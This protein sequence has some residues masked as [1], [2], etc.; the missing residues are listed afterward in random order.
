MIQ[1]LLNNEVVNIQHEKADL[2]VLQFLREKRSM[3]G[4]KEGC[5]SGD[6][7]ACT[8]VTADVDENGLA[9][10]TSINSCIT[11]LS[12]LHG[13]QVLTVEHLQ[14][15]Q[16][17]HPVQNA[18][19]KYNGSQ[20]GFCTPGF[21]MS[22]FALYKQA[23]QGLL[24]K[25]SD[26]AEQSAPIKRHEVIDALSGNLCRCTGYRP[27]IEATLQACDDAKADK[28]TQ[29]WPHTVKKL[30]AIKHAEAAVGTANL[31][32][33][34]SRDELADAIAAYPNAPLLAGST[35]LAL[36]STQMLQDLK[37][38]ISLSAMSSLK[39]VE[40]SQ[41]MLVIGAACTFSETESVLL[42]YFPDLFEV[43]TRFASRPIRNQATIG[44]NVANASPIG[45]MP[46]VLIA[47]G[48]KI[49]LDNGQ[50]TRFL[51]IEDFFIDYK[52]TELAANEWLDSIHIPLPNPDQLIRVYK[53][54]KRNEDDISAVCLALNLQLEEGLIKNFNAG[55]GGVAAIPSACQALNDELV[56]KAWSSTEALSLAQQIVKNSFVPITDV[57]ASSQYRTQILQNLLHR[58]WLET[59]SHAH[60]IA[61][62]V[63]QHA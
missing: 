19:V 47:L 45:D 49:K 38:M 34:R 13:K 30:L 31:L 5:A 50:T 41:N 48:A 46:P 32:M 10:Y 17:L 42:Q 15:E 29:E 21:V 3:T 12:A 11:F 1:F 55:F 6:C 62:R 4:T 43:I 8:I 2:T 14:N 22:M 36:S 33:P 35:D 54:S 60:K 7:G 44:G 52:K 40:T 56:N 53:V 39:R 37:I 20:C 28:F 25:S 57:R 58:F 26:S 23:E 61:T 59:N 18:M 27:I 16:N 9:H 51:N 63:E 24:N